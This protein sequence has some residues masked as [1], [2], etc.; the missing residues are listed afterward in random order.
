MGRQRA[1][2]ARITDPKPA[3][4]VEEVQGSMTEDEALS[5]AIFNS[6]N[7][8]SPKYVAPPPVDKTSDRCSLS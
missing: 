6:L 8:D 1:A 5:R 3:N 4:P 2:L 7:Q